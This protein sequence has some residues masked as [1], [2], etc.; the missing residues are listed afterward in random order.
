MLLSIEQTRRFDSLHPLH[1]KSSTY[2]E[3]QEKLPSKNNFYF[4][5]RI[6]GLAAFSEHG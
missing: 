6:A 4:C 2:K 3:V 5:R 1:Y